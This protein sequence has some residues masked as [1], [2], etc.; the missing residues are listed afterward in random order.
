MAYMVKI[1]PLGIY[2]IILSEAFLKL[3][4][5]HFQVE[6]YYSRVTKMKAK[7]CGIDEERTELFL[8]QKLNFKNISFLVLL[9]VPLALC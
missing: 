9:K 8:I 6:F 3:R 1:L 5:F 4:L 7:Y 2:K